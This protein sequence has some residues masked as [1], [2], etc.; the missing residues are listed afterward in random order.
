M[1]LAEIRDWV[2]IVGGLAGLGAIIFTWI[3]ARSSANASEIEKVAKAQG[4]TERRVDYLENEFRHLPD[5]QSVHNLELSLSEMRGDMK[6][7][8]ASVLSVARTANR[9]DDWL[10]EKTEVKQT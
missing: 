10:R 4:E 7:L 1:T 6:E 8:T 2:S 9:I 5:G 3:T